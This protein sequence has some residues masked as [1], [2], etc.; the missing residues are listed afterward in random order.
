MK[1]FL[2]LIK[3]ITGILFLSLFIL[4]PKLSTIASTSLDE[5]WNATDS[6]IFGEYALQDGVTD[7]QSNQLQYIIDEASSTPFLK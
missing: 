6:S 5:V 3:I 4:I 2:K 7:S 1:K